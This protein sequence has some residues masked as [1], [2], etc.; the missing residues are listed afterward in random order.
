MRRICMYIG[1]DLGTTGCKAVLYSSEG[2]PLCEFNK[3]YSLICRDGLVEQD[4]EIWWSL[5]TEAI[6]FVTKDF[7]GENVRG[8]SASTQGIAVVPVD[9]D[10]RTL[11]NAISW[12]DV[13]ATEEVRLLEERFGR[14]EIYRKT[15]KFANPEYTLP[16]LMWWKTNKPELFAAAHKFLLPLDFLN[17]R[18]TGRAICDYTIA[19]GTMAYNIVSKE[20]DCELLEFA[21]IS[22]EKLPE[23]GCMGDFVGTILPEVAAAT[24]L[25]AECRVYLGGQ[26]QKLAAIGAGIDESSV[27]VSFG[28]ATAV[29]KLTKVLPDEVNF[30]RF[31]FNDEYYSYEGVVSTSG[32]ALKWAAGTVFG[33]KSYKELDL[34][35]EEA[36]T[37]AGVVFDTDLTSNGSISGITLG[38]TQGNIVYA[39]FEGV[40]RAIAGFAERMGDSERLYVFGG[41]SKSAIWCKILA[42]ISGKRIVALDTPETASLGAAILA[43]EGKLSP[44]RTLREYIPEL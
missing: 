27:T 29:T 42:N 22:E 17:M 33:G 25:S 31:R 5:V 26:D 32:A 20:Y 12:L 24:G 43:S 41:G 16:K 3:E 44:A 39:L 10:G 36:G 9:R 18:L 21:G 34:L 1:I 6:A 4:A 38:T 2:T 37:S 30:S 7:G 19:G 14:D 13:R 8:I 11:A 15:G 40:S 28:T 23:V 35:A